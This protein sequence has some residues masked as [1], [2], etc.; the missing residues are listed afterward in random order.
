MESFLETGSVQNQN[1]SVDL[2]SNE[3]PLFA[4]FVHIAMDYILNTTFTR[5]EQVLGEFLIPTYFIVQNNID[6]RP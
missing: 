6:S 2:A 1:K 4:L 3:C 5:I